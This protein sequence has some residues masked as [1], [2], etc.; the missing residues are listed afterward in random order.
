MISIKV[1]RILIRLL[2]G[3]ILILSKNSA[4][5]FH[6]LSILLHPNDSDKYFHSS[7]IKRINREG[8]ILIPLIN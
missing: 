2:G 3:N 8:R 7:A 5:K 6:S 4:R 1:K